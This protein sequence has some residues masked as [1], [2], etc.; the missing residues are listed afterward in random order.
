MKLNVMQSHEQP[1]IEPFVSAEVAAKF[2]GV[3]RRFLLSLARQG[4]A[5]S[6][7][8]GTGNLRKTWIFRLKEL[9]VAIDH[10]HPRPYDPRQDGFR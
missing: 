8:I 7:P 10:H 4:L 5:G 6:Y 3:N 9:G 2:L 1:P